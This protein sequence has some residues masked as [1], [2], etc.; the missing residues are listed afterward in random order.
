MKSLVTSL[1]LACASAVLPCALWAGEDGLVP[2]EQVEAC[3]SAQAGKGQPVLACINEAQNACIA[4]TV[5]AP[6]AATLCFINAKETWVD[7]IGTRMAFVAEKGGDDIAAVA[8]IEVKYDLLQNQLQCQRMFELALLRVDP[9]EQTQ[10]QAARCEATAG[11]LVYAKLV[12]QSQSL[13]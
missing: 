10:M 11:G 13:K 2:A 9:S 12:A 7:Y 3:V 4:Y 5:D 6:Q 8:G 1:A